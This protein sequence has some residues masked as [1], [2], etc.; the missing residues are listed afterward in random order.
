MSWI[1]LLLNGC[2]PNHAEVSGS[3][4]TWLA[5]NSSGTVADD[6]FSLAADRPQVTVIDCQYEPG[7]EE[8]LA[9]SV[10]SYNSEDGLENPAWPADGFDADLNGQDDAPFTSPARYTWLND[11]G[12]Y[13][14]QDDLEPWRTE[15]IM[16]NEGDFLLTVHH[17]LGRQHDMRFAIAIDP[18]FQPTVCV[19][20]GHSCYAVD[21]EPTDDDGDGWIDAADPDCLTGG[22]E[23]GFT[24]TQCNDGVDNDGDGTVDGADGDCS[25]AWD[26]TEATSCG[27]GDDD[28][29]DG[30]IDDEDPDCLAGFEETD[31]TLNGSW[32]CNDDIDNDGDGR[33]D[34]L[35]GDCEDAYD[36]DEAGITDD[37][38]CKDDFDN[39]GDGWVD[40]D[41]SDC[42]AFDAEA[43]WSSYGC[44]DGMDNDGDTLVDAEDP[45]CLFANDPVE[46]DYTD[47]SCS[48]GDDND[49]DGWAD[50]DDPD[51]IL[52]VAEDDT[53]YGLYACNDGLNNEVDT[54]DG[55]E[56]EDI[57]ADDNRCT[58]G[59][60]NEE[61]ATLSGSCRDSGLDDEDGDGWVNTEDPDCL[62]SSNETGFSGGACNDGIDNDGDNLVDA[63]DP[64]CNSAWR[65]SEDDLAGDTDC[66][67]GAD[68]DGDGWTDGADAGCIF[69]DY[70]AE[71]VA[72]ECSDGIDNDGDGG[73]DG[74]GA[75]VEGEFVAD[76]PGCHS[77][78]DVS[79]DDDVGCA[80]LL[81]DDGD[82][83]IDT[84]DPDCI[85]GPGYEA[86]FS[87]GRCN[88]G[89]DND[90]DTLVDGDDDGCDNSSDPWEEDFD[91]CADG[92]DNDSD[93]YVDGADP[94]C[95]GDTPLENNAVQAYE[96][97]DGTDNDGDGLIDSEDPGCIQAKSGGGTAP[98]AWDNVEADNE[99]GEPVA[100]E[101]DGSNVLA[102]WSEGE[103]G[104][105]YYLNGTSLQINPSDSEDYWVLPQEWRSGF[106]TAKFSGEE[107]DVLT[108]D[109]TFLGISETNP[110]EELFNYL[111]EYFGTLGDIYSAELAAY[112]LMDYDGFT[113]KFEDNSWRPVDS[114]ES[115]LDNWVE[116]HTSWVRVDDGSNM[117]VGGSVSG[118]FQILLG[119]SE[120]A[121][122]MVIRG[123]FDVPEI[124][125]EKYGYGVL[126]DELREKNGTVV[127]E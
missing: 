72:T 56:D 76:D 30:W 40:G 41:D 63:D 91:E 81:D 107:F 73:I 108:P 29:V 97:N 87:S 112:G 39:D 28:D 21:G 3:F 7:N 104:T 57:D 20:E 14:F 71:T 42:D 68:N 64:A 106:A 113:T 55:L 25:H 17:Q 59:M 115:G 50:L 62:V 110:D 124:Q 79:E 49:A 122:Q 5:A 43:G 4:H 9:D 103:D 101:M 15:A 8:L 67:D 19:L 23:I 90:G 33:V 2:T 70:E 118:E 82:G 13:L 84:L 126:E 109:Y 92:L 85:T 86:G 65:F 47:D 95:A 52:G 6:T 98:L 16:N 83:Y 119:G 125:E 58:D 24:S 10:C 34:A 44:N 127:C 96:C 45:G 32:P 94:D 38:P 31:G 36:V 121:S 53:F 80:N 60:D 99:P 116:H 51:C 66:D 89:L 69:E 77:S 102:E 123:T 12:F 1:V 26:N 18:G 37:D 46:D 48:D 11:D 61:A 35:D 54:G 93:G 114:S 105:V 117:E 78:L 120:A 111:S 74:N 22:W 75:I 27:N 100:L 88:D